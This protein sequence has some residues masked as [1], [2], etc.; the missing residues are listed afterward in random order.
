LVSISVQLGVGRDVI[1]PDFLCLFREAL[2]PTGT[3]FIRWDARPANAVRDRTGR[4][5]WFDF[6]RSVCHWPL[7]DVIWLLCDETIPE[8]V[9]TARLLEEAC[10]E[11]A[12]EEATLLPPAPLEYVACL[13]VFD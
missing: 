9:D 13:S 4:V 6:E 10:R 11:L 8:A 1:T 3:A 5:W 12:R 2:A 7:D